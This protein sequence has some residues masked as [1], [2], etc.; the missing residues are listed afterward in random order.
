MNL[1]RALMARWNCFSGD[2]TFSQ[3]G[4]SAAAARETRDY[5]PWHAACARIAM[6]SHELFRKYLTDMRVAES[7]LDHTVKNQLQDKDLGAHPQANLLLQ[8]LAVRTA[9]ALSGLD[10]LVADFGGEARGTLKDTL[11]HV[12]GDV[13]GA[14][15]SRS[16]PITKILRDDYAT[17]ASISIGYELLHATANALEQPTVASFALKNLTD[18]AGFTIEISQKII[19]IAIAE[20]NQTVLTNFDTIELS[21]ANIKTAWQVSR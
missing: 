15:Q 8:K 18:V 2:K 20:V 12:A 21:Q 14:L 6:T 10:T 13:V 7:Q 16:H 17:L 3:V 1:S 9:S 4:S 11:T 5:P 19:P